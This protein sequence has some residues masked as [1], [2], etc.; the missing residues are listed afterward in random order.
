MTYIMVEELD[1]EEAIIRILQNLEEILEWYRSKPVTRHDRLRNNRLGR[2]ET[3][4]D[5]GLAER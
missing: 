3:A 2:G 4:A 5:Y 1:S